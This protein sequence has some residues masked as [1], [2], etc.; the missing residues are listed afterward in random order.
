MKLTEAIQKN[1]ELQSQIAKVFESQNIM[2]DTTLQQLDI[3]ETYNQFNDSI[4]SDTIQMI[5]EC[6][7]MFVVDPQIPS[8]SILEYI[9]SDDMLSDSINS[10]LEYLP[11]D[12]FDDF[13]NFVSDV[14]QNQ[15][16][17]EINTLSNKEQQVIVNTELHK[18]TPSKKPIYSKEQ[19]SNACINAIVEFAIIRILV[20]GVDLINVENL[21]KIF[22]IIQDLINLYT[23]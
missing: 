15:A 22:E 19:F 2:I 12:T 18:T 9:S 23:K 14:Y 20:T 4:I 3:L 13:D 5:E 17:T 8:N 11:D 1:M 10:L 6:T 21:R 16:H 7:N